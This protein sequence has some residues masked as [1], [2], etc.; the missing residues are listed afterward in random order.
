MTESV[1]LITPRP[2]VRALIIA[3][4]DSLLGAVLLVLSLSN[5]WHWVGVAFGIVLLVA[6]LGL[7]ALAFA[8]PSARAA[9]LVIDDEGYRL[10]SG[11]QEQQGRWDEVSRVTQSEDGTRVT[12][13]H[14]PERRN[15]LVFVGQPP[16]L[17]ASV[18]EDIR[19]QLGRFSA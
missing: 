3:G 5:S 13:H 4:V 12:I 10:T 2:P 18:L 11:G 9:R 16:A 19:A 1:H 17:V 14:G 8:A 6:G 7:A 15:H